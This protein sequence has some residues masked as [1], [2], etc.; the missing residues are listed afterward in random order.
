MHQDTF[1]GKDTLEG[2]RWQINQH[3][4]ANVVKL[5]GDTVQGLIFSVTKLDERTL[6]RNKGIAKKFYERQ[7]LNITL[8]EHPLHTN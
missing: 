2:Y 5:P 6:D 3:G 8:E 1:Q 4:V 7:I